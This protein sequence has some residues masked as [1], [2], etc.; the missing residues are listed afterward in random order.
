MSRCALVQRVIASSI[1]GSTL[2]FAACDEKSPT[3]PSASAVVTFH[4]GS[5][6]FRARVVGPEQI[7]AAQAARAGGRANI[8]AGRLAAGPEVNSGWSWHMVDVTFVEV[9]IELCDGL[10]SHVEVAGVG[11]ANGQYCPW[12]ARVIDIRNE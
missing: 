12:G 6:T 7:A 11:Y 3:S 9:A 10:P 8:P 1:V 4:V 5:E 2:W